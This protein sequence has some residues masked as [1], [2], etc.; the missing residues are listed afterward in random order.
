MRVSVKERFKELICRFR[1]MRKHGYYR[2]LEYR[3]WARM[4][5]RCTNPNDPAWDDYG[6]RGIQIYP[7]W[8]FDFLVFLEDVGMKPSPRLTLERIDNEGNYEPGNV[9]WATRREQANNKRSSINRIKI[10]N[11][12][13]NP[14]DCR[15]IC[16]SHKKFA[17]NINRLYVGSYETLEEAVYE[18]NKILYKILF[19]ED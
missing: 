10:Q 12:L 1:L 15:W 6:G 4:I 17:V 14:D 9:K 2:T 8:R 5:Q 3:A 13:D 19:P 18:R 16:F 7:K 11:V